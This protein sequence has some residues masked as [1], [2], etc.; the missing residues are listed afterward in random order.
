MPTD[1]EKIHREREAL[2]RQHT[3]LLGKA[4]H[5]IRHSRQDG[6][7]SAAELG[8]SLVEEL[9]AARHQLE[10]QSRQITELRKQLAD[11]DELKNQYRVLEETNER[12]MQQI[13]SMDDDLAE[14]AELQQIIDMQKASL[15]KSARRIHE[16]EERNRVAQHNLEV[17]EHENRLARQR[18]AEM[19]ERM[20]PLMEIQERQKHEISR[21]RAQLRQQEVAVLQANEAYEALK[22]EYE[23]M[24]INYNRLA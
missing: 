8:H 6:G 24:Y 14:R 23:A 1:L 11:Y 15:E 10:R 12:L 18:V 19:Q 9:E 5:V 22:A 3:K 21:L 20:K 17:L 16:L 4:L 13:L 7:M 2:L